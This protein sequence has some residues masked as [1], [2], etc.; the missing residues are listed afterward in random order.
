MLKKISCGRCKGLLYMLEKLETVT[1]L[2]RVLIRW[3][4]CVEAMQRWNDLGS[5]FF[6]SLSKATYIVSN[7]HLAI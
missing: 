2:P 7:L 6:L 1:F 5:A 3:M 4:N